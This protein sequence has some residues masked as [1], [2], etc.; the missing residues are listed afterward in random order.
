MTDSA[1]GID[2]TMA[3]RMVAADQIQGDD[4][5][6]VQDAIDHA[7]DTLRLPEEPPVHGAIPI[8]GDDDLAHAYR[9][10]LEA[11]KTMSVADIAAAAGEEF[12]ALI[13]RLAEGRP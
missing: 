4:I 1:E 12:S 13:R 10:V 9:V 2:L 7:V 3:V 8:E 6:T 5:N 11:Y